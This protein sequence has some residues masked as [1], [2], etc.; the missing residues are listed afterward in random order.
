MNLPSMIFSMVTSWANFSWT[1]LQSDWGRGRNLSSARQCS[2]LECV[3]MYST[4]TSPV[5]RSLVVVILNMQNP[6]FSLRDSVACRVLD[7]FR[8]H[9]FSRLFPS[10]QQTYKIVCVCSANEESTPPLIVTFIKELLCLRFKLS[11]LSNWY[12]FTVL[13]CNFRWF[14]C[15]ASDTLSSC[16]LKCIDQICL[17]NLLSQ[18]G[19]NML[20]YEEDNVLLV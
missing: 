8:P 11:I 17:V 18:S 15:I 12:V 6:L 13:K 1:S 10:Q 14:V 9:L 19:W 16:T 7:V 20:A 5:T 3:E 4:L 2:R